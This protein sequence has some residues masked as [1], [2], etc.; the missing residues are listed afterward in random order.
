VRGVV[1]YTADRHYPRSIG[2]L[3]PGAK[4]LGWCG[5]SGVNRPF[6]IAVGVTGRNSTGRSPS[7]AF[8][9][10]ERRH[11]AL[12]ALRRR[13]ATVNEKADAV[14]LSSAGIAIDEPRGFVF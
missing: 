6:A 1:F 4:P 9:P 8:A 3:K 5:G 11:G 13:I 14:A 7:A 10:H 12:H 2:S